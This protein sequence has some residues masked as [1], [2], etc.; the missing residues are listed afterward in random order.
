MKCLPVMKKLSIV[1][2]LAVIFGFVGC[3][4]REIDLSHSNLPIVYITTPREIESKKEW[5]KHCTISIYN[6]GETDAVYKDVQIKGRGN[7]TWRYPKKPYAIKLDKKA[8]V[9]G[10]PRHKRWVLLANYLDHTCLRNDVSFEIARCM[11]G[12]AWTPHGEFVEV[13]MNGESLGNYYLCEQIKMDEN[14]VNISEITPDEVTG[15]YIF[16]L[17]INYDESFKFTTQRR[18]LPVQFKDPDENIAAGQMNYVQN[19]FNRIENILYGGNNTG[20]TPFDYID[21]DSFIDWWLVH[22]LTGN[23]EPNHPKSCYM[24]KD[25]DG[26]LCAG[27]VWD[28]DYATFKPSTS[29][30][31]IASS[32]LW[33]GALMKNAAFTARVKERWAMHKSSLEQIEGY[34]DRQAAQIRKSAEMNMN[35][36]PNKK[37]NYV[38]E[39]TELSFTQAV[40]RLKQGYRQRM[41]VLDKAIANM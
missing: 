40:E 32:S 11:P 27:P 22:E 7:S 5:V 35:R 2:A 13:V 18:G 24:Y 26:K 29:K 10:M 4:E 16:E 31:L 15:G 41:E 25:R 12:L 6:S 17:D 39:D 38:N 33:Y 37:Y 21:M 9:L 20:E 1:F 19:Y 34:I 28:F 23:S 8:E 36:W 3:E 30:S 14:R